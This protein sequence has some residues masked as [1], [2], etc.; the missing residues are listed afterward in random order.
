MLTNKHLGSQKKKEFATE[1]CDY[2]KGMSNVLVRD[3]CCWNSEVMLERQIFD[4]VRIYFPVQVLYLKIVGL[5]RAGTP[6]S[7]WVYALINNMK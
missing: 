6:S 2:L 3:R 1:A 5:L 7:T 4:A